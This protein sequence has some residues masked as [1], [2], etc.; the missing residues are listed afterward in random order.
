[1][2]LNNPPPPPPERDASLLLGYPQGVCRWYPQINISE[3]RRSGA[4][5][6][7]QE[8]TCKTLRLEPGPSDL[9][10]SRYGNRSS[11]TRVRKLRNQRRNSILMMRHYPDLGS[12][13]QIFNQSEA[14]PKSG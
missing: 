5:C 1:M 3:E 8:T 10:L 4:K 12:A 9:S 14:Q 7:V 11:T 2:S 6:H 13:C